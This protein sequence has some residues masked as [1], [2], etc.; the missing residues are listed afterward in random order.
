MEEPQTVNLYHSLSHAPSRSLDNDLEDTIADLDL[1]PSSAVTPAI[2]W[3]LFML[4]SAVLLPWNVM[5]TAMPFFLSRLEGSPLR[6]SFSS[7]LSVAFTA[8]NLCFLGLATATTKQSSPTKRTR[9]TTLV[10]C[11]LTILLTIST[12]VRLPSGLFFAF[13]LINSVAQAGYGSYLQCAVVQIASVFGPIGM[14]VNM[15][16]QAAVAVVVSGIQVI[17]AMMSIW[18][19]DDQTTL[20]SPSGDPAATSASAFFTISAIFLLATTVAHAWLIRT[21]EYKRVAVSI[22]IQKPDILAQ[23]TATLISRGREND[24]EHHSRLLAILKSNA[25]YE[26]AVALVFTVTLAVFPAITTSVQPASGTHPLLFSAVHFF[27]FNTG[28]LGGRQLCTYP[29]F[30][31]WSDKRLLVMSLARLLFIPLFL[32]CNIQGPNGSTDPH[33]AIISSD[34]IFLVLMFLFGLTNGYVA[35]LCMIAAPS[36]E[37]NPKLQGRTEDIDIAATVASFCLVIGLALGSC[38]SFA[39]RSVFCQCNPFVT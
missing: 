7:Y 33:S 12:F 31:V 11:L 16:G 35:S 22:E 26:I 29:R 19:H 30:I 28:D 21:P 34:F 1:P 13:V 25:L 17:S 5:I 8:A 23:E 39:V 32:L 36:V 6:M 24:E 2:R 38:A 20:A 27:M 37:H 15:Q 4:G 9:L 14:S 3:I 10:L 18:A